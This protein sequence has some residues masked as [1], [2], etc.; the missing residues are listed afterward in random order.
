MKQKRLGLDIDGTVTCPSTFVPYLNESFGKSISLEDI[1][2][3]NLVPLIGISEKEF[4][5]WMDE[6]EARIYSNSP[7]SKYAK[8][9]IRR[10]DE[11]F[12]LFYISA[13]RDH[14]AEITY[15]WFNTNAIPYRHIE[16]VGKHDKIDAVK[17]HQ[18]ELFFEDNYENACAIS[19]HCNIPVILFDTPYNRKPLPQQVYRMKNWVEASGWIEEWKKGQI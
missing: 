2:E 17:E 14:L 15:E 13:R 4:W 11:E 18:V 9:T 7:L 1:K 3:Y 8:E 5:K 19:E 6:N 12:E 10:L 16:L